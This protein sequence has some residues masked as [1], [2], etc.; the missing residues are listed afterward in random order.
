MVIIDA[1]QAP[2]TGSIPVTRS[3]DPKSGFL[4]N[5]NFCSMKCVY[6]LKKL[7]NKSKTKDHILPCSWFTSSYKENVW[8]VPSCFSCNQSFQKNEEELFPRFALAIK[9]EISNVH[10][11]GMLRFL[12]YISKDIKSKGRNKNVLSK[13]ANDLSRY[14]NPSGKEVIFSPESGRSCVMIKFPYQDLYE[15]VRKFVASLEFRLRNNYIGR[16]RGII[17]KLWIK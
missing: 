17:F 13:I 16:K 14:A 11:K 12:P 3:H 2:K 1:S 6:C 4:W 7:T 10:V 15:I 8:T 9:P 5:V